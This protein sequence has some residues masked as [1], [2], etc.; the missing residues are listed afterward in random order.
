MEEFLKNF[1][2]SDNAIKLYIK[3]LGQ[4]PLSSVELYSFLPNI[5]HEDF[6]NVLGALI[7]NGL[8]VP[9]SNQNHGLISE[10]LAIPPI[11]PILNYYANISN[12]LPS[13]KNK[14]QR[15]LSDSLATIFQ[16]NQ[17][18]EL[19]TVYDATIELRKDVRIK[20]R[21]RRRCYH[22]ETRY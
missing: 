2:L 15:L 9:N 4:Q 8:F 1:Q 17:I 18:I 12:N 21:C 10:Y 19:D 20:K 16:D 11:K 22:P 3:C 14:L 13:I 6:N 5:S 7:E